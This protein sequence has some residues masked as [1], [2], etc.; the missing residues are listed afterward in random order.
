[1]SRKV[2]AL[3]EETLDR[4]HA[5]LRLGERKVVAEVLQTRES[6]SAPGRISRRGE[7]AEWKE[8]RKTH[9]RRDEAEELH[10]GDVA[11]D[12]R[13]RA[14]RE[15]VECLLELARLLLRDEPALGAV[16]VG[17][18]APDL[19]ET[20][21]RVGRDREDRLHVEEVS[22]STRKSPGHVRR[23]RRL[24]PAGKT[25]PHTSVCERVRPLSSATGARELIA[26]A[27]EYSRPAT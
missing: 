16:L 5:L 13:A 22:M 9:E 7:R 11:A 17:V 10:H 15:D 25:S 3:A 14:V 12:A 20:V 26:R 4:R 2:D 1:M 18:V 23:R 27:A 8:E 24:T 21:D 19:L 6:R